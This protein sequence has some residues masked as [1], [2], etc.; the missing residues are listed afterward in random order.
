MIRLF[1][2]LSPFIAYLRN[3]ACP[4]IPVLV[5]VVHLPITLLIVLPVDYVLEGLPNPREHEI[6]LG[7]ISHDMFV[8]G[9]KIRDDSN[10]RRQRDHGSEGFRLVAD[11][12][13]K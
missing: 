8:Q 5:Q 10:E 11:G 3:I 4:N 12:L 13:G 2:L 9:L 7:P 6:L 1:L